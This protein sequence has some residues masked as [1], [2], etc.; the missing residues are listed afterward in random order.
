MENGEI[1]DGNI[2][3]SH[4][5]TQLSKA[6]N[7]R[8]ND[9]RRWSAGSRSNAIKPWI[10]ADIGDFYYVPVNIFLILYVSKSISETRIAVIKVIQFVF[11]KNL[12]TIIIKTCSLLKYPSDIMLYNHLLE[13][14]FPTCEKCDV[15]KVSSLF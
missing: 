15:L 12:L 6:K 13:V 7:G 3:A 5:P 14:Y 1:P 9:D 11:L 10:Q 2:Q 8:L 4:D